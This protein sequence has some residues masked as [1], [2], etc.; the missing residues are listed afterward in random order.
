MC[1]IFAGDEHGDRGSDHGEDRGPVRQWGAGFRLGH[2]LL[3]ARQR[4]SRLPEWPPHRR[5]PV[6]RLRR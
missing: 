4:R 3:Q 5:L 1:V 2:R 6:R